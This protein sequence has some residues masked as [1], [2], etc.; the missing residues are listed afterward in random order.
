MRAPSPCHLVW[1]VVVVVVT[2]W[3]DGW[4]AGWLLH[5]YNLVG[6]IH[7]HLHTY[8]NVVLHKISYSDREGKQTRHTP[9]VD[10]YFYYYY[11]HLQGTW[12]LSKL[13]SFNLERVKTL[14]HF[15]HRPPEGQRTAVAHWHKFLPVLQGYGV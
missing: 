10:H 12:C 3:V 4:M 13:P 6:Y 9:Q 8:A 2:V 14:A 5:P 15:L 7:T 11:H 1:V